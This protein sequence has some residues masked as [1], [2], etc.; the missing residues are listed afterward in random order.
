MVWVAGLR[1]GMIATATT[2]D[3]EAVEP[4]TYR[5]L[6][7]PGL[8]RPAIVIVL[9]ALALLAVLAFAMPIK[10]RQAR[11]TGHWIP[12]SGSACKANRVSPGS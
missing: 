7:P 4:N 3:I 2:S 11:W 8:L 5:P 12:T 6:L 10:R 9:L 1:D